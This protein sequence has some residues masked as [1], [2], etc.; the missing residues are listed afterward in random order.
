MLVLLASKQGSIL[1][2]AIFQRQFFSP[3]NN[4]TKTI[5]FSLF[6]LVCDRWRR[7]YL[8]Y[9]P[10][11][12]R[13]WWLSLTNWL[14]RKERRFVGFA[15]NY[16]DPPYSACRKLGGWGRSYLWASAQREE[17]GRKNSP[18]WHGSGKRRKIT[19]ISI[20]LSLFKL[21]KLFVKILFITRVLKNYHILPKNIAKPQI[22]LPL[23]PFVHFFHPTFVASRGR[24]A[25]HC[26][27]KG[28]K[29][30]CPDVVIL[31]ESGAFWPP[32]AHRFLNL[33]QCARNSKSGA[34]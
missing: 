10:Q 27:T 30:V 29:A 22:L 20:F 34:F 8:V 7:R 4:C 14:G 21:F 31:R 11:K 15:I 19:E 13:V 28:K 18:G 12:N 26:E 1:W 17:R 23:A 16:R 3:K 25:G 24:A 5:P 6:Q 33:A 9:L 32:L 2:E